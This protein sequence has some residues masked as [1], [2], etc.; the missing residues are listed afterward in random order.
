M[1]CRNYLHNILAYSN[2]L[3]LRAEVGDDVHVLAVDLQRRLLPSLKEKASR[4]L[5][6][7]DAEDRA[8]LLREVLR[9]ITVD[10]Q[11]LGR[12]LTVTRRFVFTTHRTRTSGQGNTSW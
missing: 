1:F 3:T 2:H 4:A 8:R 9:S 10:T 11:P 7:V 6:T 5:A 12:L